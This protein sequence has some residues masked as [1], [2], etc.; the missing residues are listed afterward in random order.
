[1]MSNIE[2]ANFYGA[3]CFFTS[4]SMAHISNVNF[5]K[6]I[7]INT[8]GLD[9]QQIKLAKNWNEAYFAGYWDEE[10]QEW[11]IDERENERII[12][13]IKNS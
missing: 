6:T 3:N 12:N 10:K 7:L 11:I 5:K 8:S 4:F 2:G 13:E 9:N 1:M